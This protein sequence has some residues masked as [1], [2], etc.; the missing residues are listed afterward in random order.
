MPEKFPH[1]QGGPDNN[2]PILSPVIAETARAMIN[3]CRDNSD[4]YRSPSGL[5]LT[6]GDIDWSVL[7]MPKSSDN[8]ETLDL[9]RDWKKLQEPVYYRVLGNGIITKNTVV[10]NRYSGGVE[11]DPMGEVLVDDEYEAQTLQAIIRAAHNRSS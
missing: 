9:L 6:V 8:K 3:E 1:N 7:Y 5:K 11:F 10:A 2:E 4:L